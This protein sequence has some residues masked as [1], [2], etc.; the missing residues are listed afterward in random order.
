MNRREFVTKVLLGGA[1]FGLFPTIPLARPRLAVPQ[2]NPSEPS[3][4]QILA[5]AF[6]AARASLLDGFDF[7]SPE[8][9]KM[10]EDGRIKVQSLGPVVVVGDKDYEIS[11][12][13]VPL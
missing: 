5:T 11:E 1:V 4:S 12:I 7:V 2:P 8:L 6:P 3:I 9:R 13:Q 10:T